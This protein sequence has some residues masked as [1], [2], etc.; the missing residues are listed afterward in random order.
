MNQIIWDIAD[1]IGDG[2]SYKKAARQY[3]VEKMSISYHDD[4]VYSYFEK[5]FPDLFD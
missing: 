2:D 4:D 5:T 3:F 1:L